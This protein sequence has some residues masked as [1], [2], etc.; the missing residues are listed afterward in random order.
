[1]FLYQEKSKRMIAL[2]A[3]TTIPITGICIDIF[4]PSLPEIAH[5]FSSSTLEAQQ[6]VTSYL[7]SYGIAQLL[8]GALSDSYGR[9]SIMVLGILL[10]LVATL[11]SLSTSSIEGFIISR[12]LQGIAV[13]TISSP[14]RALLPDTFSGRDYQKITNYMTIAWGIG[15]ILAPAIGSH[16]QYYFG[17][18]SIMW[19]LLCY[20]L[21]ILFLVIIM[22][23]TYPKHKRTLFMAC[24]GHYKSILL[25][26]S[27]CSYIAVITLLYAVLLLFNIIAPFFMQITMHYSVTTYGFLSL[28]MGLAWVSGNLT[29]RFTLEWPL[30]QKMLVGL[31]INIWI[32]LITVIFQQYF[33]SIYSWIISLFLLIF[34]S[35]YLFPNGFGFCLGIFPKASGAASALMGTLLITGSGLVVFVGSLLSFSSVIPLLHIYLV[36]FVLSFLIIFFNR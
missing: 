21:F 36:S 4:A 29:N 9:K 35:G 19:F 8:S 7:I 10:F 27:F 13:G 3:L 6:T 24:F 20:A 18:K 14:C 17:W 26:A 33:V 5:Y 15:P 34:F 23:E 16:L 22:P 25:N 11:F 28:L 12:V 30:R 31:M 1:M 2:I 32:A